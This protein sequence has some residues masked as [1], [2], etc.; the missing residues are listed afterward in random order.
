MGKY[1]FSLK[2]KCPYYDGE[3]SQEIFCRG[4]IADSRIHQGFAHPG[5]LDQQ[6]ERFC[7]A[8][9]RSCPVAKMLV[10]NGIEPK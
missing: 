2:V 3:R 6:K 9:W 5:L 7:E 8:D 10:Q 1:K 4:V